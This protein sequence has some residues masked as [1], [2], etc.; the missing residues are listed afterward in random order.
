MVY[1]ELAKTLC[2]V[3]PEATIMKIALINRMNNAPVLR[4]KRAKPLRQLSPAA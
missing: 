1:K 4:L 3:N 2:A